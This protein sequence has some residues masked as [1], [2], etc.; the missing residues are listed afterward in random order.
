MLGPTVPLGA[1]LVVNMGLRIHPYHAW[2]AA[3]GGSPLD[4]T[5]FVVFAVFE[6]LTTGDV[7]ATGVGETV[8]GW[9]HE[10][11]AGLGDA[12]TG[13]AVVAVIAS[14]F[15]EPLCFA[16]VGEAAAGDSAAAAVAGF[17]VL[18]ERRLS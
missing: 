11:L 3:A 17:V 1:F 7:A 4:S 15:L 5:G 13:E 16:G 2:S 12:A 8:F 6:V 18:S 14:F 10:R 9:N